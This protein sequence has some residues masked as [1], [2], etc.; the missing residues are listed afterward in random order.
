M[1]QI[2]ID[3]Q[4]WVKKSIPVF[5]LAGLTLVFFSDVLFQHKIF[6]HRDLFR[7]FYPLREF[8][9]SE[10]LRFKI[11]LWDPYIHCGSPHMAELQTCVFYPLSAIYLLF[12]YPQ[13][14]NYFITIHILLAGLF[15][16]I[17]MKE[18]GYSGYA[19]FLSAI[20]FMF[21]GYIISV[22]NLLASLASV[23][24]LP[25]VILFYERALKKDWVKN[26]IITGIF[27]TMMFLGGE[28]A[29]LLGTIFILLLLTPVCRPGL[30]LAYRL[31]IKF[32]LL[33]MIVFLGLASFQILPFLE[34]LKHT[35]RGM[36][37]FNEASMWSLP[38]YAL[39]DLFIPYLSESDYIYKD[40]WARQSWLLAYY[41]GITTVIFAAISMK[42]DTTKRRRSIFY[43]L[44]LGI[45]LSLE[46]IR[47]YIIYFITYCLVSGFQDTL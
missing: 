29:I 27:M 10:F 7:F 45:T 37:N 47:L 38:P 8:S 28:P 13:A 15:I 46:D 34:F 25:L 6:V 4:G 14:F 36:M 20:V 17:L 26:S 22:I 42:F 23:V 40:Y 19:C 39:L 3:K 44:A 30:N 11:P 24:W 43:I 21:S 12:P 5:I 33:A 35:S 2:K 1:K 16:F 18:W 9:T 31:R 32:I 41:M